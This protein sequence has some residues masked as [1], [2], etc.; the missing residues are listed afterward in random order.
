MKR[1]SG[2]TLIELM[3]VVAIIA[4]IASIA[5][6]NL[7][8]ARLN[9]NEAAAIA[10][11]KNLSSAQAQ[12]LASGV[13]V[14]NINGVVEVGCVAELSGGSPGRIDPWSAEEA[15]DFHGCTELVAAH[16][17]STGRIGLSGVVTVDRWLRAHNHLS[18]TLGPGAGLLRL[19]RITSTGVSSLHRSEVVEVGKVGYSLVEVC[20]DRWDL[21]RPLDRT[22]SDRTH[23]IEFTSL[24]R[25]I[26]LL[27]RSFAHPFERCQQ[28]HLGFRGFEQPRRDQDENEADDHQGPDDRVDP[29]IGRRNVGYCQHLSGSW[30]GAHQRRSLPSLST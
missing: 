15:R 6:P 10:T 12:T 17:W 9:A 21:G 25:R 29:E 19:H 11:L 4:I 14:T 30:I 5:I 22:R 3:I 7:L 2:F 23:V 20:I 1:E 8:S 28:F 13:S 16:G 24:C 18:G 26:E 27:P